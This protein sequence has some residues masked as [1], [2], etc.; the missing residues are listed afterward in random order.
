[1]KNSIEND[2][3]LTTAVYFYLFKFWEL[4]STKATMSN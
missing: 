1:M 3:L 2:Y 4:K